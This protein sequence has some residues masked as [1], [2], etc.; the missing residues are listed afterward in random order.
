MSAGMPSAA[1]ADPA[2]FAP[3]GGVAL[4]QLAA[5]HVDVDAG[6][7]RAEALETEA[8]DASTF[9]AGE[10][11][12]TVALAEGGA[13]MV[14]YRSAVSAHQDRIARAV[15]PLEEELEPWLLFLHRYEID[16]APFDMLDG[17]GLNLG[18][19]ARLGRRWASR[20]DASPRLARKA[21]KGRRRILERAARRE[22]L[23]LPVVHV[24]DA[25]LVPSPAGARARRRAEGA[26]E[27]EA[28]EA[29]LEAARPALLDHVTLDVYAAFVAALRVA[30][31]DARDAL[32]TRMGLTPALAAALDDVWMQRVADDPV[33]RSDFRVLTRHFMEATRLRSRGANA[34]ANHVIAALDLPEPPPAPSPSATVVPSPRPPAG[35]PD[36]AGADRGGH[37]DHHQPAVPSPDAAIDGTIT[38]PSI[39]LGE[40]LPFV[41]PDPDAPPPPA[42]AHLLPPARGAGATVTLVPAV[43]DAELSGAVRPASSAASSLGSS[44]DATSAALVPE[45]LA[46][47]ALPFA[48][49]ARGSASPDDDDDLDATGIVA[50]L[51]EDDATATTP[52]VVVVPNDD[53]AAETGLVAA[54]TDADLETTF[55]REGDDA[56]EATVMVAALRDDELS[57]RTG[58]VDP[59]KL[60]RQPLPFV[61]PTAPAPRAPTAP[62]PRPV[63]PAATPGFTVENY[64]SLAVELSVWPHH[65]AQVLARYGV[66][67]LPALRRVW[68]PRLQADPALRARYVAAGR[69]YRAWLLSRGQPPR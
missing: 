69:A 62:A 15:T 45:L 20:Y 11:A 32:L 7:G 53:D 63:T 26:A 6:F 29:K 5:V 33:L 9:A 47:D 25:T 68:D 67:D 46:L 36:P 58:V 17:L 23:W 55:V 52:R 59:S 10:L 8:L 4:E 13:E 54:L 66:R 39:I 61:A 38:A 24:G 28:A 16:L 50:A 2:A 35:A 34:A 37:A 21:K 3:R 57:D 41:A 56:D 19:V 18:D 51:I 30:K 64:A 65:R 14:A 44:I 40:V 42:V 1:S 12:W 49:V 48:S 60:G 31:P 22:P 27:I 43:S